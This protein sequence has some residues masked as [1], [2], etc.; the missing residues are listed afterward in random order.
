MRIVFGTLR[1]FGDG[2]YLDSKGFEQNSL[3]GRSRRLSTGK[4]AFVNRVHP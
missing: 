2:V 1:Q 3:N 4:K